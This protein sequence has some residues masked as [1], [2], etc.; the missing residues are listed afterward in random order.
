MSKFFRIAKIIFEGIVEGRTKS[1]EAR[2]R[3]RGII[4]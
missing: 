3:Q 4:L 2:L 1:Y